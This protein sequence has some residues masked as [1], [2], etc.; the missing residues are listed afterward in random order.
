MSTPYTPNQVQIDG[1]QR[2]IERERECEAYLA[3]KKAATIY[4]NKEE[5]DA[6]IDRAQFVLEIANACRRDCESFVTGVGLA[7]MSETIAAEFAK[8]GCD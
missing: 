7:E 4:R 6:A 5:R 8:F 3:A 2:A 1:L